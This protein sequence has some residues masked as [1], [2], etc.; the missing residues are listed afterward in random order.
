[1]PKEEFLKMRERI[2]E[3]ENLKNKL[4]K[5]SENLTETLTE[6]CP[7]EVVIETNYI[8]YEALGYTRSPQRRC[9][10]CGIVEDGWG[11]GYRKLKKRPI[12]VVSS[13]VFRKSRELEPLVQTGAMIPKSLIK[14]LG[15]EEKKDKK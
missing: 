4:N 3:I 7:H 14:E 2:I 13:D 8:S 1:M 6:N 10:I 5:E 15:W 9:L 11:C 12:K